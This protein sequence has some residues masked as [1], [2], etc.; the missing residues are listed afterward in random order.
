MRSRQTRPKK[1]RNT[2]S[3]MRSRSRLVE[4]R[5]LL[6]PQPIHIL[7]DEHA[8]GREIR[9]HAWHTNVRVAPEQPRDAALLLRLDLV[10]ELIGD[11]LAHLAQQRSRVATRRETR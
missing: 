10:V 4:S 9:V 11:P 8:S 3:P 5:D 2:I 1:K 7:G 6:E